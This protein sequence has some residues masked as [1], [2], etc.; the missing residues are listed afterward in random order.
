MVIVCSRYTEDTEQLLETIKNTGLNT[1]ILVWK[2]DGFLPEGV[3]SPWG[4][5]V[6]AQCRTKGEKRDLFYA[7]L[8]VPDCWEIRAEGVNGA[9]FDMGCKKATIYFREPVEKRNVQ[10]VEWE[11][12]NGWV[13]K[14]DYYDQYA[15]KYA[16]EF[17]G[18]DKTTESRVFYSD[19]NEEILVELPQKEVVQLLEHGKQKACFHSYGQFLECMIREAGL[20]PKRALFIQKEEDFELLKLSKDREW[21]FVLFSDQALLDRYIGMG[22]EN[23]YEFCGV[24][25]TCPARA[26]EG[27]ALILTAS[28]RLEGI[29]YLI[30]HLEGIRFHIAANTQVSD[31]IRRLAD[32]K[33]V[34]IYPQV[35]P[36]VLEHLW[37]TCGF[38][39]DINHYREI[40]HA[41]R[42]ALWHHLLL[43]GFEETVHNRK[44]FAKEHVFSSAEPEKMVQ[45]IRWLT[46]NAEAS[47]VFREKQRKKAYGMWEDIQERLKQTE[48]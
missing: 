39:L 25:K 46:G 43:L 2:D 11:M 1:E 12:E 37:E 28:D 30:D 5:A 24:P 35:R 17:S 42:K 48:V 31:K 9:V 6:S 47:Q 23:G 7:F 34:K 29:D 32:R 18:V 27:E 3:Q 26:A 8:P 22:G 40:H 16:S 15:R 44:L 19:Q 4:Y 33:N 20:G 14:T 13:Y 41:V 10:R 21:E 36:D 45:R 38:Y